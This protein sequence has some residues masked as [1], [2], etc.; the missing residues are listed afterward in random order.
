MGGP[1]KTVVANNRLCDLRLI[2]FADE[3]VFTLSAPKKNHRQ[4]YC[5]RKHPL[6]Q[7]R[8]TTSEQ[9]AFF[10]HE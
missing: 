3:K 9:N 5:I 2:W 6:Q 10:A 7:K 1:L 4:T 8:R